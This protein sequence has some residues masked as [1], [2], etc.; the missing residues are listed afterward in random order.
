MKIAVI[1]PGAMGAAVAWRL[2]RNNATVG[3]TLQGRGPAS[4]T[5]AQGLP[6]FPT[7]AALAQ[8]ADVVLSILPPGEALALAHRLAPHL[9]GKIFADCNAVSPETVR[10]IAAA[11]PTA[12]FADIG[13][14]GGPPKADGAGPKLYASGPAT[15]ALA[16]L[17]GHG[18]DLRPIEGGTGAASAL[19]MSYGGITKGITAIASAMTIGATK[20]GVAEVLLAELADSQPDLLRLFRRAIPDMLPKAYR[21]VAEMEEISNFLGA[22]PAAPAYRGIA[23]LYQSIA[24]DQTTP[25]PQG[26]TAA[27]AHFFRP[28]GDAK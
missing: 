18:V 13:I 22:Q 27:L 12:R 10:Q 19:K 15:P 8:W 20:A 14:I 21:W 3:I 9:A 17:R 25:S 5:R 23:A 26:P 4:A 7:E 1:A 2:H 6:T 16:F 28:P 24:E 11:V